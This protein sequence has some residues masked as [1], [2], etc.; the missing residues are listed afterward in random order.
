V[1]LGAFTEVPAARAALVRAADSGDADVQRVARG[2]L[3]RIG[4]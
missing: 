4:T 1:T 3:G 2:V